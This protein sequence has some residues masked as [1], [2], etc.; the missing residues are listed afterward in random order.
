VKEEWGKKAGFKFEVNGRQ[1][2]RFYSNCR[3]PYSLRLS[4]RSRTAWLDRCNPHF[5][6]ER[7]CCMHHDHLVANILFFGMKEMHSSTKPLTPRLQEAIAQPTA[8][9]VLVPTIGRCARG[10]V[11]LVTHAAPPFYG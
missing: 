7:P 2:P 5:L 1:A 8:S 9:R 11:A 4:V 10:V 3:I 6:F